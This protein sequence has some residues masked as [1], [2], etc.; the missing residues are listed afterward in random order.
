MPFNT[1][2]KLPARSAAN[3]IAATISGLSSGLPG[4]PYG[5]N[6]ADFKNRD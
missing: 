4:T 5:S 2:R 1:H 3:A 6:Q